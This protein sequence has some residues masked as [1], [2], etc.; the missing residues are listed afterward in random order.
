MNKSSTATVVPMS[1]LL[2]HQSHRK[3]FCNGLMVNISQI[4]EHTHRYYGPQKS[5]LI[6]TGIPLPASMIT[7]NERYVISA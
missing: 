5:E 1:V 4:Y 7:R 6:Q 3:Q 2:F